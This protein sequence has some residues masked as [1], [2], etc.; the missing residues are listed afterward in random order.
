VSPPRQCYAIALSI[1]AL[2]P[3]PAH[4]D[5]RIEAI[6]CDALDDAALVDL[7]EIETRGFALPAP[8]TV[9]CDGSRAR[10]RAWCGL[11]Q[12]LDLAVG[13]P[14]RLVAIAA[15]ELA[16][17]C[18][19]REPAREPARLEAPPVEPPAEPR[20]IETRLAVG[21]GYRA[22]GSPLS[23]S[24]ALG[25]GVELGLARWFAL[26]ADVEGL[27]GAAGA[28]DARIDLWTF[29]GAAHAGLTV[30]LS[31]LR[32]GLAAGYRVLAASVTG[33]PRA[34]GDRGRTEWGAL[35]GPSATATFDL[36]IGDALFLRASVELLWILSAFRAA[37]NDG[38]VFV[39]FAGPALTARLAL[40]FDLR[41]L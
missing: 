3:L 29:G 4:A 40:G 15:A 32:L 16:D 26:A 5:A 18:P 11:E 37:A 36:Q 38:T 1:A 2:G 24:G 21:V 28:G 30:P 8:F 7:V 31:R 23:H 10:L 39:D 20:A 27:S 17:A 35:A 13:G 41:S 33:V 22:M 9:R 25:A 34:P 19:A 6:G 12:E 14:E